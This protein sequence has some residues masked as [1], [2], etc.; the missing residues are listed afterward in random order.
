MRRSVAAVLAGSAL[1]ALPAVCGPAR[2]GEA[3]FESEQAGVTAAVPVHSYRDIPFRSVIRQ[4]YDFSCGSAALATLLRYHYNVKVDEPQVFQGMWNIGDHAKIK[5]VGFSLL[6]MKRVLRAHGMTAD[7]F[8][9][10]LDQVEA[11]KT[12][13]IVLITLGRYKHFVVIKGVQGGKVLVGDPAQGLKIYAR[14][15]FEKVWSGVVFLI[16]DT[17]SAKT[18][19]FNRASEWRPFAYAPLEGAV[20]RSSVGAFATE[21]P[22]LYQIR[23]QITLPSL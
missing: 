7:G 20:D 19:A 4:R 22:P 18:G 10:T 5:T 14:K 2:A 15:D 9:L 6:D 21:L 23:P 17:P 3:R 11:G 1:A 12:P 8:R 13:G 16:H